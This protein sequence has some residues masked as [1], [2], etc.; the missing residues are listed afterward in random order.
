MGVEGEPIGTVLVLDD[1][2]EVRALEEQMQRAQR[3]ARSAGSQEG[4][5]TRSATH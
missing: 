3:L 5:R 4:S 2:T 1:L